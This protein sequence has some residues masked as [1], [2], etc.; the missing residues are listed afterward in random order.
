M[1]ESRIQ[2]IENFIRKEVKKS[3]KENSLQKIPE[4][5]FEIDGNDIGK[6]RLYGKTGQLKIILSRESLNKILK[7]I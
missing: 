6:V 3:L 5:Y 1:K 7:S 4:G 2:V